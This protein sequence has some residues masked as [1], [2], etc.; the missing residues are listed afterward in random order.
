MSLTIVQAKNFIGES[1]T[2]SGVLSTA[3][4][5]GN[6]LIAL[7]YS[8]HGSGTMDPVGAGWTDTFPLEGSPTSPAIW[9]NTDIWGS[10]RCFYK[11]C[12]GEI[13]T[14]SPITAGSNVVWALTMYEI[15]GMNDTFDNSFRKANASAPNENLGN[16]G[17]YSG[18]SDSASFYWEA[19]SDSSVLLLSQHVSFQTRLYPTISGLAHAITGADA[20]TTLDWPFGTSTKAGSCIGY[21]DT[22]AASGNKTVTLTNPPSNYGSTGI[23][24]LKADLSGGGAGLITVTTTVISAAVGPAIFR[25]TTIS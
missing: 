14:Q 1:G 4:T 13:T 9:A 23:I 16:L 19:G 10:E 22:I 8:H 11:W 2:V 17:I 20:T 7:V 3:P 24:G 6:L 12:S 25:Y 5:N 18:P 21:W 15:S